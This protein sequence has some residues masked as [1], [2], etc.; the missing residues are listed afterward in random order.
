MVQQVV[1]YLFSY[2]IHCLG[3]VKTTT[4]RKL[5]LFP[6]S[7]GKEDKSLPAGPL[8]ELVSNL[9]QGAQQMRLS[10]SF[11]PKTEVEATSETLLC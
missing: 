4:F 11:Q 1:I 10:S 9:V 3:V 8:V 5:V 2:F 6:S 7:G